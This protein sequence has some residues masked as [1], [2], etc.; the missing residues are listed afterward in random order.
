MMQS[1]HPEQALKIIVC[2][3]SFVSIHVRCVRLRTVH[4]PKMVWILQGR[5]NSSE[6]AIWRYHN[7]PLVPTY[8]PTTSFG[9]VSVNTSVEIRQRLWSEI[10][11]SISLLK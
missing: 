3:M 4:A 10:R 7:S 8:R 6:N 2:Q 5:V 11:N 9:I 1:F